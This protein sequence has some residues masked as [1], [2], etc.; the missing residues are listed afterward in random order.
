MKVSHTGT[1]R[2]PFTNV[3]KECPLG[4]TCMISVN[5]HHLG[6][7]VFTVCP[8]NEN[9]VKSIMKKSDGNKDSNGGAKKNL[10]FIGI[11]GG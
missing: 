1:L 2:S 9:T 11:N 4:L 6:S 3:R 5:F 7:L 10:Q 8:S